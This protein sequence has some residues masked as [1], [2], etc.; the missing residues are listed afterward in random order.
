NILSYRRNNPK[1]LV[2]ECD[3]QKFFDTVQHNHLIKVFNKNILAL[4]DQGVK[5]SE[6]AIMIFICFLNSYSYNKNVLPK[7]ETENYF[8]HKEGMFSWVEEELLSKFGNTYVGIYKIG[9]PQGN[10]ISCFIANLILD[11][12]DKSVTGY[13][14]QSLYVRYCDDM[15]LG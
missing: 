11:S 3:I 2:A 1:I 4:Q 7:N 14:E 10:A 12:V 9:I 6:K 13:N 8:Q 5:V 15:I